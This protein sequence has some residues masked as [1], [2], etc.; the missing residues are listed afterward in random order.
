M[1][2]VVASLLRSDVLFLADFH[3][4]FG[5]S[6]LPGRGRFSLLNVPIHHFA[7]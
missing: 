3:Y 2:V 1:F 5:E 6:Q 4:K 7:Q